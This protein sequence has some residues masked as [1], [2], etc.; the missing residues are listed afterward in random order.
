MDMDI[1]ARVSW[2]SSMMSL[3]LLRAIRDWF[4]EEYLAAISGAPEAQF[5]ELFLRFKETIISSGLLQ[6]VAPDALRKVDW[7]QALDAVEEKYWKSAQSPV[8]W[9][10]KG[11][12]H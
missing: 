6:P 3:S 4:D 1:D 5:N 8:F 10:D 11:K 12:S 2:L 7:L 9:E